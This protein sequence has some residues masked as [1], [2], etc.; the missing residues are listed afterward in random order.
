MTVVKVRKRIR[1]RGPAGMLGGMAK[2]MARETT[3]RMPAHEVTIAPRQVGSC[4]RSLMRADMI[5][6]RKVTG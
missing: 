5:R 6:G 1:L 2:A 3:P 4:S